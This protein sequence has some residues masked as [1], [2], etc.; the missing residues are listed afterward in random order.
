MSDRT[1][2][3]RLFDVDGVLLYVGISN[4]F[5]QRWERHAKVQ[6]WWPEVQ[7]QTVEWHPTRKDAADAETVAIKDEHPRFNVV[8]APRPEKVHAKRAPV[9]GASTLRLD[10]DIRDRV[11]VY[12]KRTRR[13]RNA[14]VNYLAEVALNFEAAAA[15]D[16]LSASPA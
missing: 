3:Y 8:H 7:R 16:E 12:A 5:G 2:V 13:S 4:H 15:A 6:P 9:P 14:T 10:A 11:D 1:A